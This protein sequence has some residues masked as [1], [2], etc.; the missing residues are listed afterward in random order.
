M[1]DWDRVPIVFLANIEYLSILLPW[2]DEDVLSYDKPMWDKVPDPVWYVEY[3]IVA[4]FFVHG[5]HD[6]VPSTG[7]GCVVSILLVE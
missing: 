7:Y 4:F 2:F 5:G 3:V 1:V 6:L